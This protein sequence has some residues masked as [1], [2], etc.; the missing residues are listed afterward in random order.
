MYCNTRLLKLLVELYHNVEMT[1][2]FQVDM[3]QRYMETYLKIDKNVV[4]H[5]HE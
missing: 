2:V 1:L 3:A 4:V 5:L